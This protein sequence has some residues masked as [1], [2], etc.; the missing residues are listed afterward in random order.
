MSMQR[1]V[2]GQGMCNLGVQFKNIG[3]AGPPGA[4]GPQGISANRGNLAIVDSGTSITA[5]TYITAGSGNTWTLS[6]SQTT[7]TVV[8]LTTNGMLPTPYT[9]TFQSGDTD[10]TF[11][12][13]SQRFN[14]GDRLHLFAIYTSGSPTNAGHDVT[15]QLDLF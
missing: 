12:S 15:M 6:S 9:I 3:P 13:A 2:P 5:G 8:P 4:T 10:K 1:Y 14:T 11:Y 7:L